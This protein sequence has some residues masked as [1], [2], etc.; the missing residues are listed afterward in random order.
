VSSVRTNVVAN[1]AGQ[2]W[3]A[4]LQLL[5]VPLYLHFLGVEAYG[6]VG[7]YVVLLTTVQIF[8]LGFAQTLNRELARSQA[9]S[10]N[11]PDTGDLVRTIE[12]TYWAIVL[13]VSAAL[14]LAA[15]AFARHVL[16]PGALDP[17]VVARALMLMVGVVALQWPSALYQ[18]GL[19]GLQ[20]Q[21]T[22][23]RL[24]IAIVT[25]SGGGAACVL[26]L[27]S[28]TLTA[29]FVWQ[30]FAAAVGL[31][32][33]AW[34]FRT[35]LPRAASR[36]EFRP[37][38]LRRLWRF[39]AGVSALTFT[40]IA[41]TQG[42]KWILAQ[43]LPL[44]AFGYFVLAWTA[45]NALSLLTAPVFA[46]IYPRF[47]TLVA[48]GDS[49]GL[50]ELYHGATQAIAAGA[51]PLALLLALNAEEVL[52]L[53]TGKEEV[54]YHAAPL[55]SVLVLGSLLNGL[56]HPP[57]ASELAHGRTRA[58]LLFN[59]AAAAIVLPAVWW[60]SERIG[61]MAAALAWFALNASYLLVVIPL[62]HR[63][64]PRAERV[65]WLLRDIGLPL[66]TAA[67]VLL[68]TRAALPAAPSR[69]TALA[70]LVMALL[71]ASLAAV[72]AA[73]RMRALVLGL[74]SRPPQG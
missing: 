55:L 36:P 28:P 45:A 14:V 19:M 52:R 70:S 65:R 64:L 57:Y 35:K 66:A 3:S 20:Q 71:A 43:R 59:L 68:L 74:V 22:A 32:A 5:L 30:L 46:A 15:P 4:G 51:G 49:A 63:A 33:T 11:Q 47:S 9:G 24:R 18:S 17:E 1:L 69:A 53:W 21:V 2:G 8:D 62:V 34:V 50:I 61:A 25:F 73:P 31:A 26:W 48:R 37:A 42:D 39:A 10:G 40:A 29:F 58:F 27:V 60:L 23:N 6:V 12:L 16:N 54:A 13:T 67:V 44:E 7:M 38:I 56:A 41:L 72:W